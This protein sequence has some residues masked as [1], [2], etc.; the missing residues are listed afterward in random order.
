MVI[1]LLVLL[2]LAIAAYRAKKY[3]ISL[4]LFLLLIIV[5]SALGLVHLWE[6]LAEIHKSKPEAF[7]WV[8][9][10]T[11]TACYITYCFALHLEHS[12]RDAI[13][14]RAR[15]LIEIVCKELACAIRDRHPRIGFSFPSCEELCKHSQNEIGWMWIGCGLGEFVR[16]AFDP[17]ITSASENFTKWQGYNW[18][19]LSAPVRHLGSGDF[20]MNEY[21]NRI[22]AGSENPSDWEERRKIVIMRDGG[23]C[24]RCGIV[25]TIE[26]C[27]IH[28]VTRRADGGD[29]DLKNLVTLCRSCHVLMP[30]HERMREFWPQPDVALFAKNRLSQILSQKLRGVES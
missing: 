6:R 14:A 9:G 13:T 17:L 30:G 25:V 11:T 4:L 24:Q 7:W 3:S 20:W 16:C 21:A 12:R 18:E 29:H 15:P 26:H 23:R 19:T 2:F 1:R 10:L 28:H 8:V 27:H 22:S 5:L